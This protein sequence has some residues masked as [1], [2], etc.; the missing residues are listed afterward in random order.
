MLFNVT[1]L[2]PHE[3]KSARKS[4][5][6]LHGCLLSFKTTCL[7]RFQVTR[8]APRHV[9]TLFRF[10]A[11]SLPSAHSAEKPYKHWG[12]AV[13]PPRGIAAD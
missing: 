4:A 1:S 8:V 9:K 11:A 2:A 13:S 10:I 6:S 12:F 5:A 7:E 3:A